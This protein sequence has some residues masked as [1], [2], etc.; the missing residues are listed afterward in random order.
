MTVEDLL[1]R[2]DGAKRTRRGWQA[3]CPAHDDRSPSLSLREGEQGLL[4]HC[5]AGCSLEAI[6]EALGLKVRELFYSH[7]RD[8]E[9]W[10]EASRKRDADRRAREQSQR[11][12]GLALDVAREAEQL[13]RAAC[14]IDIS[15]WSDDVLDHAL[16]RLD[17]AYTVLD[18]EG[19]L[20]ERI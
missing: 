5:F 3:R 16:S 18:G 4:L 15:L 17:G 1:I 11:K 20:Y 12:R 2:L 13:L 9:T 10:R 19:A 14:E 7:E 8:R 6:C